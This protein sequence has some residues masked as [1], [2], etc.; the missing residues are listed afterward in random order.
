MASETLPLT[1]RAGNW[2]EAR[3]FL[4]ALIERYRDN[5]GLE[6]LLWRHLH[7]RARDRFDAEDWQ[8]AAEIYHEIVE[9]RKK[10]DIA[11]NNLGVALSREAAERAKN[12]DPD[13]IDGWIT[14]MMT[15]YPR[16]APKL[17]ESVSVAVNNLVIQS[18]EKG[19]WEEA[20]AFLDLQVRVDDN[21]D[22]VAKNGTYL[23]QEWMRRKLTE[24][25]LPAVLSWLR[26]KAERHPV[27]SDSVRKIGGILAGNEAIRLL[28]EKNYPEAF[29]LLVELLAYEKSEN[30]ENNLYFA[31]QEW[32]NATLEKE[33]I[34]EAL[35]AYE[36]ARRA[37]PASERVESTF[38]AVVQNRAVGE[39]NA[40]RTLE[41]L[42]LARGLFE[43]Y[44][45]PKSEE[46]LTYAAGHHASSVSGGG[47]PET[48]MEFWQDLMDRVPEA[49]TLKKEASR[50]MN[51]LAIGRLDAKD[52]SGAVKIFRQGLSWKADDELLRKNL[53][54]AYS[55]WSVS[56]LN[57]K[58]YKEGLEV[59]AEARRLF[60]DDPGLE[61]NEKYGRSRLGR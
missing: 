18:I 33:G 23:Y 6:D 56:L 40:G 13:A 38:L 29:H 22:R 14:E 52:Y 10:D 57:A 50:S 34:G 60:P 20:E 48:L 25:K 45:S 30:M 24:E 58:K 7:R 21:Q 35:Q 5:D 27:M 8:N 31:L 51:N 36:E 32:L 2:S 47:D 46:L 17:R 11:F 59:L 55:N 19:G 37:L 16:Q 26:G 1:R 49:S 42:D 12:Q 15:R 54:V 3:Q 4:E 41:G 61:Q 28:G 39:I 44:R 53:L 9:M 43:K